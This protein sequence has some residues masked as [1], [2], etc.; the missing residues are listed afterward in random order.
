MTMAQH[1]SVRNSCL[2]HMNTFTTKGLAMCLK[3]TSGDFVLF[4]HLAC[5]VP[6][7]LLKR[8]HTG[9]G[10]S[11]TSCPLAYIIHSSGINLTLIL[12]SLDVFQ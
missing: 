6:S 1:I 2:A 9:G 11:E 10:K 5:Y 12:D 7:Q 8:S 4:V 3:H